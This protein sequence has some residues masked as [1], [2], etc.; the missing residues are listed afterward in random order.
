MIFIRLRYYPVGTPLF[1]ISDSRP[2]LIKC[3]FPLFYLYKP[4]DILYPVAL[5]ESTVYS[6]HFRATS[7]LSYSVCRDY[8]PLRESPRHTSFPQRENLLPL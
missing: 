5:L 4:L 7:N 8:F 2:F 3:L 6:C 1:H